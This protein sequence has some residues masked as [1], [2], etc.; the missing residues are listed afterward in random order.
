MSFLSIVELI[1]FIIR[2]I[3]YVFYH[4]KIPQSQKIVSKIPQFESG[5]KGTDLVQVKPIRKSIYRDNFEFHRTIYEDNFGQPNNDFKNRDFIFNGD[6]AIYDSSNY[7]WRRKNIS[8][9]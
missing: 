6:N 7:N 5:A 1:F 3:V 9:E 4:K 8:Y 2:K